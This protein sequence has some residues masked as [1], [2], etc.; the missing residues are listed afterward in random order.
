MES[1]GCAERFLQRI[2]FLN[3]VL[4]LEKLFL[5]LTLKRLWA[6]MSEAGGVQGEAGK[7]LDSKNAR[8]FSYWEKVRESGSIAKPGSDSPMRGLDG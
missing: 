4:T 6:A 8:Y 2:R 5:V 7:T 3:P 1:K